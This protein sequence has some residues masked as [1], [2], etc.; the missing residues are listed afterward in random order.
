[1]LECVWE[2]G[3]CWREREALEDRLRVR[4][5]RNVH[6]SAKH[7]KGGN[8]GEKLA[9]SPGSAHFSDFGFRLITTASLWFAPH[10]GIVAFASSHH[11]STLTSTQ[12][13]HAPCRPNEQ[14]PVTLR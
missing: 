8:Q 14:L 9:F 6:V 13:V 11:S 12:H 5:T 7:E 4:L 2:V 3:V 10:Y 1:M